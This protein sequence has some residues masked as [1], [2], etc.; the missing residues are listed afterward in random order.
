MDILHALIGGIFVALEPINLGL[1][2]IGVIVGLFVG[3]MPGLG[4]VNGVAIL[5]P[6]T[7]VIQNFTGGATSPMI[8]LAA[9]YY[10]AMYGGAISS[11]TLGIPG[12][13]TAVATT[14]DGR[15]MALRGRAHVALVTA[16]L[17]SFAGGTISN[18][19]FTGFAPMLAS[20]ALSF[21]NPEIFALMLL[22]FA[23]FVG[24]GGDDIPKTIFSICIGLVLA[25]V[26][27][28]IISGEPRLIFFDI[29]GFSH[30][31]R[32]LVLAIGVYG[33]GEMLWTINSSRDG[34]SM[35]QVDVSAKNILDAVKEFPKAWRGTMIGS[36]M[37]F[38]VGILPAAG[39]TPGSL[40]SYGVTKLTSKD[41]DS[42]GK[43]AIDG[44]AAPEAAN[45]SASTGAM[46]PMMTL[47]IPGSPTTAVLLAGMVIWGLQP[48]PLL[49]TNQ[50]D[51]VWPL[52]G[53]FYISNIIAVLVNLAFIPIFLWMLRM[54]FTIL[55]PVIFVLSLVGTYAAY[56]DLFDVGLMVIVGLVAFVLR[57]LDYP[58]AP[59]VLA[60]VLGPIAE[61]KLRQSL[62]LS[63]GDWSIF[64]TRP[65]AG[66]ITVVAIILILL[67]LL[68]V[69]R[70]RF[71]R[72]QASA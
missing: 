58:L 68:K 56:L 10:G 65:I 35:S 47:G 18:V 29:T 43:G 33:I 1:A 31:F 44:V 13:S 70:D 41:P 62:L 54:P 26:G 60:I 66:P 16:A 27:F 37:G 15:P 32:F 55:A 34:S 39:A 64:F 9:I 53:S 12:A 38:F 20:V 50:P 67:P 23:T 61:P 40:M 22:A 71:R 63:D 5:L 11:I 48:G 72:P 24:L 46:L 3:A 21:G 6:F 59:A 49:F 7:F 14:F 17:A 52:I 69:V 28:D 4:S 51:F 36:A 25:T 45:N 8:F 30:G 42:F 57:I 2:I 19:L